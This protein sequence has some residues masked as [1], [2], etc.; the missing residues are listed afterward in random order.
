MLLWEGPVWAQ[1]LPSAN[2][3]VSL[4]PITEP[5][6]THCNVVIFSNYTAHVTMNGMTY[7]GHVTVT[8][9]HNSVNGFNPGGPQYWA[10]SDATVQ[11]TLMNAQGATIQYSQFWACTAWGTRY[12]V[13][14]SWTPGTGTMT[15]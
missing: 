2:V 9:T 12:G 6:A 11:G 1:A 13:N 7:S 14:A 8:P 10:C 5:C 4:Y 15:P 3:D